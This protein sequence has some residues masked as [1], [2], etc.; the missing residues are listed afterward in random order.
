[1]TFG[2]IPPFQED[3]ERWGLNH[4]QQQRFA[5][6]WDGW[7]RWFDRHPKAWIQARRPEAYAWYQQQD[8]RRPIYLLDRDATVAGDT[9]YPIEAV[10]Q[11]FAD[12]T[13]ERD[14]AGSLSYMLALAIY[15]GFEAIDLFWFTLQDAEHGRQLPSARYWIGQARGRGIA[16]RIH[17]DSALA[18]SGPL[19]GEAMT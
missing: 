19:Y 11:H 4:L 6:T 12:G 3:A 7:T 9:A 5:G 18:A 17:G 16:V 13:E 15:E 8:G 2:V 14:F 1:M 10:Q